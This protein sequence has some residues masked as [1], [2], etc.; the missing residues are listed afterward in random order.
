MGKLISGLL[1]VLCLG[2]NLIFIGHFYNFVHQ[3]QQIN[4][5][6]GLV[7]QKKEELVQK[8]IKS[9]KYLPKEG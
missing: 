3:K 6:Y 2:A 9:Y 5:D 1:F 4:G 7:F 8:A